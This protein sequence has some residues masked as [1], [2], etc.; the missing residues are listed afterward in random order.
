MLK[1][2]V[3]ITEELDGRCCAIFTIVDKI[4]IEIEK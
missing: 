2:I 4:E 3:Q 1:F